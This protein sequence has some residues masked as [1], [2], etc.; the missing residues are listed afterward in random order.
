LAFPKSEEISQTVLSL[1]I[2]F[3]NT[4][5]EIIYVAKTVN[6]FFE[7]EANRYKQTDSNK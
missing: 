3:G 5:E 4:S 6:Q 7:S 2:S 1:P